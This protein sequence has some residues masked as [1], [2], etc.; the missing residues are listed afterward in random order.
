MTDEDIEIRPCRGGVSLT[1]RN[2][3]FNDIYTAYGQLV[4]SR[5]LLGTWRSSPDANDMEGMFMLT[6]SPNA[7]FMYG[8]FTSPNVIGGTV[9][10]TWVL[11]KKDGVEPDLI[12]ERLRI[13]QKMLESVTVTAPTT[14]LPLSPAEDDES[15]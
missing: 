1:S 3:P 11:A 8:Y 4:L 7:K 10:A 15:S 12:E 2:N 5:Q 13:G 9:Y 6:I 14:E